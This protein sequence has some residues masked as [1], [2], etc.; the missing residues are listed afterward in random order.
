M[1]DRIHTTLMV[2]L[3]LGFLGSFGAF[4]WSRPRSTPHV[5]TRTEALVARAGAYAALARVGHPVRRQ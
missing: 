4:L 2:L 3:A 1:S 5:V